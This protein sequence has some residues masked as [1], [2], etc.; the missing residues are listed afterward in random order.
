MRVQPY[1]V[2]LILVFCSFTLASSRSQRARGAAVFAESGCRHCHTMQ[3]VGGHKGPDLSGVG[4]RKSKA[5]M[6]KQIVYGSKVMPAFGD[7]L[8][9][10]ELN[11]LIAYLRSCRAKPAKA[12]RAANS[13]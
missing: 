4:R 3:N 7:V 11:D 8:E 12:P 1:V 5:A 10:N 13:N 6:R 2:V 9:P